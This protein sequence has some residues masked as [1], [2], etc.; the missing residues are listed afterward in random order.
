MDSNNNEEKE[1]GHEDNQETRDKDR[2]D[3]SHSESTSLSSTIKNF[4]AINLIVDINKNMLISQKIE[5]NIENKENE[6]NSGDKNNMEE[7]FF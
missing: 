5:Y 7:D 3:I 1:R 6:V 4:K 2:L